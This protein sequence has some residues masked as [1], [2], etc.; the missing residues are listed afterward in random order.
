MVYLNYTTLINF[1]I[2][3]LVGFIL[4]VI[5]K[6]WFERNVVYRWVL[7]PLEI[8]HDIRKIGV[9]NKSLDRKNRYA[10]PIEESIVFINKSNEVI[11]IKNASFQLGNIKIDKGGV[12]WVNCITDNEK[13]I[14]NYIIEQ[15]SWFR[16]NLPKSYKKGI[17][18][19][20]GTTKY[21]LPIVIEPNKPIRI[22]TYLEPVIDTKETPNKISTD[23]SLVFDT[24]KGKKV[25]KF[26]SIIWKQ[27]M[28]FSKS[29]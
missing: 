15:K 17:M 25:I 20:G 13:I 21:L 22:Y 5:I 29:H 14:K 19:S 7:S 16:K 23:V 11:S 4:G 2:P 6:P 10:R 28:G 27:L 3:A 9:H 24:S 12:T 8:H 26:G 18:E 1:L